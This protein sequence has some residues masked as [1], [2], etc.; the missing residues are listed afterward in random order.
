MGITQILII[1][2][3]MIVF[4]KPKDLPVV[5]QAIKKM[6]RTYRQFIQSGQE[7]LDQISL[8]DVATPQNKSFSPTPYSQSASDE[9]T[10]HRLV[11]ASSGDGAKTQS[12]SSHDAHIK[13]GSTEKGQTQ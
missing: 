5:L 4:I 8:D 12:S 2:F 1:G 13:A 6:I 9:N 7:L 11:I 10:H 3:M